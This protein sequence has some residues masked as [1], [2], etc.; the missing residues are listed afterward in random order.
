MSSSPQLT[1]STQL[2]RL[3][4]QRELFFATTNNSGFE[5]LNTLIHSTPFEQ[6]I[7]CLAGL[8]NNSNVPKS[9]SSS[10]LATT[11]Q[12]PSVKITN[13]NGQVV[14]LSHHDAVRRDRDT[15]SDI[16][17]TSNNFKSVAETLGNHD[18]HDEDYDENRLSDDNDG[19]GDDISKIKTEQRFTRAWDTSVVSRVVVV[20]TGKGGARGFRGSGPRRDLARNTCASAVSIDGLDTFRIAV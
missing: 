9:S 16:P 2:Q 11:S 1:S 3:R 8:P 15:N 13:Q 6:R 18:D 19:D 4:K 10:T 7:R 12:Q 5:L 14:L 20:L 17:T